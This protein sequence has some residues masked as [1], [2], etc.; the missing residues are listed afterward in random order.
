MESHIPCRGKACEHY[1]Y[2]A[3]EYICSKT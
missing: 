2:Q 3:F 1:L